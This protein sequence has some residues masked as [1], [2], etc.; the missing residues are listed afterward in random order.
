MLMDK[1]V[2]ID[3]SS[4]PFTVKTDFGAEFKAERIVI[5]TG[6]QAKWLGIESETEFRGYGVSGC[7][8]CDGF[9]FKG[10]EVMVVGGGNTAVEE[11]LYLTNH[12]SKVTLVH[13]RDKLRCEKVLEEKL[14]KNP[15]ISI[16]WNS[17]IEEILGEKE[18]AKKVTGV[19]VKNKSGEISQIKVDGIFIAIGHKPST[20]FLL[21]SGLELD[22]EGY[23]KVKVGTTQ[24]NIEGV[25][26]A[27]DVADKVYRQAVTAAGF[28]CMAALEVIKSFE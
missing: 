7:A 6:A 11:A 18:P 10:K 15:K 2:S 13:R 26:G 23:L 14:L 12:A 3:F 24:T 27:G 25:Y 16:I 20:D 21:N 8:T 22:S 17:E 28:G 5:A 4:K 9:F 1:V 19:K